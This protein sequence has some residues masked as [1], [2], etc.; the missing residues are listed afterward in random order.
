MLPEQIHNK[1]YKFN[2][3]D[4]G[5][6]SILGPFC[7]LDRGNIQWPGVLDLFSE[8][9]ISWFNLVVVLKVESTTQP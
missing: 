8:S 6:K 7:G 3:F 5:T 9:K 4:L 2:R 1:I